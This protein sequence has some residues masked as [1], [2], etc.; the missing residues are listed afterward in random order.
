MNCL[1][2]SV[3]LVSYQCTFVLAKPL[4]TKTV[5]LYL[6]LGQI[7]QFSLTFGAQFF[8]E[9]SEQY[10]QEQYRSSLHK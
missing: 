9:R 7:P 1:D 5:E 2:A 4:L 6:F 3:P 8:H 10:W